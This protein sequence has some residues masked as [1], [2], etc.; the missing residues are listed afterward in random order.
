MG[1]YS[2]SDEFAT[3]D[4][5]EFRFWSSGTFGSSVIVDLIDSTGSTWYSGPT[6]FQGKRFSLPYYSRKSLAI[7]HGNVASNLIDFPVLI[8]IYDSDLRTDVRPDGRDI[9]F[10]IGEETLSHEIEIFDQTF[11]STH[12][13]L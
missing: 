4:D 13:H 2:S 8:D 9:A 7:S 1:P 6:S 3:G 5:I 10:A 11:N 12:A